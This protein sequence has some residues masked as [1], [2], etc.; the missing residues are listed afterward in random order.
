MINNAVMDSELKCIDSKQFLHKAYE[1]LIRLQARFELIHDKI[2]PKCIDEDLLVELERN[3]AE[4]RGITTV[5]KIFND[6]IK[7]NN[8]DCD[9]VS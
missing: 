7:E 5:I 3:I 2:D 4:R 1:E 6:M 8:S 9:E